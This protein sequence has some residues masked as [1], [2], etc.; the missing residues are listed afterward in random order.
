MTDLPID[1]DEFKRAW[2]DLD[3]RLAAQHAL[4]FQVFRDG[5]VRSLRRRL[6]PL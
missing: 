3:R 1:L 2:Q 5:R 4:A 6:W